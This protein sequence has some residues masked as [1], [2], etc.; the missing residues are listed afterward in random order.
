MLFT[1]DSNAIQ[2][3][4]TSYPQTNWMYFNRQR[5]AGS[6][7]GW[8]R[9]IPSNV[10]LKEV[11]TLLGIFDVVQQC[12][13]LVYGYSNFAHLILYSMRQTGKEIKEYRVDQKE[14]EADKME[15]EENRKSEMTYLT[16]KG[17]EKE[18]ENDH[19]SEDKEEDQKK[20]DSKKR[21]KKPKKEKKQ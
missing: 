4:H 20:N 13:T 7:A 14:E 18:K 17:V 3:A 12:D 15:H 5:Y 1:D 8:E 6:S 11:L 21:K 10:P 2:E 19:H 9:H 16:D